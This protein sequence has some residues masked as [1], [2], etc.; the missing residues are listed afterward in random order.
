[1]ESVERRPLVTTA[2]GPTDDGEKTI[3]SR[4]PAAAA[5]A[6]AAAVALSR[7]T[8][9]RRTGGSSSSSS[10]GA[11]SLSGRHSTCWRSSRFSLISELMMSITHSTCGDV[12]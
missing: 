2:L 3:G 4:W 6:A 8:E 7:P 11:L 1:M 5:A 12:E 10:G 9:I